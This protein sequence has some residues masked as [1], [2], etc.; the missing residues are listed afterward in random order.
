MDDARRCCAGVCCRKLC[1]RRESDELNN[2]AIPPSCVNP[3]CKCERNSESDLGLCETC[4]SCCCILAG[5][6]GQDC[7]RG[8]EVFATN[9]IK[10]VF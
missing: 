5:G 2:G 9:V 10:P 7:G 3:C 1:E 8:C 4:C 6:L